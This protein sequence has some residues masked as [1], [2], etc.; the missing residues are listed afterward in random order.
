LTLLTGAPAI[1]LEI[2]NG[3]CRGVVAMVDGAP[4]RFDAAREV[5]LCAGGLQT[6]KL[7]MLSG[8]GPA[9]HLRQIGIP[10]RHDAPAIGANLHDHLL[11]RVV[12]ATKSKMAPV[13]DTGNSGITYF[14]SG[15]ALPGPD[16][17]VFGKQDAPG[18]PDLAPDEAFAL[19]AALVKPKSRGDLRLT[20]ADP[21]APLRVDPNYLAEPA[22][23]AALVAG[24]EFALAL[25]NASGLAQLR[26]EQISLRGAGRAE[27]VDYV[28]A[29][30]STYFHYAGT[31]AMGSD[32]AAPVD[33]QLR[34]RGIAGLRIAD[35]SA[36]P[37]VVSC[38][39][40]APTLALA[41]R[42]AEIVLEA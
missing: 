4:R 41:E 14:K 26:S 21:A 11:V 34:L 39:T 24:V 1:R 13:I 42:A 40:H 32:P 36:M 12:F 15:A 7:L 9:D 28:R 17:Q 19:L 16:I 31:C 35:A 6:P 27:I 29:N 25:G 2:E 38:N 3:R 22:D 30:A 8:I 18:M 10:A 33:P 20:A 5:V 37:E 23:V